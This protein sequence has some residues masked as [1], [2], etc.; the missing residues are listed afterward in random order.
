[1][2]L[3]PSVSAAT[4]IDLEQ[5]F[6]PF[7]QFRDH[8]SSASNA[9]KGHLAQYLLE[10]TKE[11]GFSL[12]KA[13][14]DNLKSYASSAS[15]TQASSWVNSAKSMASSLFEVGGLGDALEKLK[16]DKDHQTLATD[17]QSFVSH[18]IEVYL[19]PPGTVSTDV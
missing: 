3:A 7:Q 10:Q 15:G 17:I 8:F 9:D 6:Q 19:P 16:M 2:S 18:A 14:E 11:H 12:S 5:T 13:A 4:G 1:M